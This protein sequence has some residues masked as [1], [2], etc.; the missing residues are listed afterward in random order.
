MWFVCAL[1]ILALANLPVVQGQVLR[2]SLKEM[3]EDAGTIVTGRVVEVREGGHPDYPNVS[4]TYITVEVEEVMKGQANRRA[5]HTFMQFG[6]LETAR[7]HELPTYRAGEDVVL[8]LY[9]ESQ[10]GFTS[11]VGGSQGKFRLRT[12]PQTGERVVMNALSNVKL[13]EGISPEKL[14][15]AERQVV[16]GQDK[17][18]SY[19]TF[20]SIVRKLVKQRE[21]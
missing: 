18:V 17:A 19:R 2:T 8:F 3:V 7:L 6:G 5:R 12:D 14:S 13:F 20:A 16:R 4:V 21:T 10:Y 11:P 9:P 1:F 15:S